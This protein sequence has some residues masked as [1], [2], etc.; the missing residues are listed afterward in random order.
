MPDVDAKEV[1]ILRLGAAGGSLELVG[2]QEQTGW[3]FQVRTDE[4]A[5][6][7]LLDDD[8]ASYFQRRPPRPWVR[9]WHEAL[10]QL[11]TYPWRRLVPLYVE[12]AF[13]AQIVGAFLRAGTMDRDVLDRLQTTLDRWASL[14]ASPARADPL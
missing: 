13:R 11:E 6:L 8:D 10:D 3:R 12:P 4:A 14:L 1:T 5:L 7:D 2:V 9:S